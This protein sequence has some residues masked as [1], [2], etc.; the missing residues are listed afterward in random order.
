MFVI[1]IASLLLV[2]ASISARDS[3]NN[4]SIKKAMALEQTKARIGD[5]IALYF[6]DQKHG[7]VIKN[8]GNFRTNKKTNAFGKTDREACQWVF[9]S[10]LIALRDRA[11]Q[12]GGNAIINIRSNYKNNLMSSQDNFQCG[13]GALIAGVALVGDIVTLKSK[14]SI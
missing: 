3:I 5:N 4:Y 1:I 12:V 9:L 14:K 10:A 8:F 7:K 13:A 2:P 6:G 11:V